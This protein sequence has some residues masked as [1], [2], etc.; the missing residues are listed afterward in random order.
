MIIKMT[1]MI[2]ATLISQPR[3]GRA[4]KPNSQRT[5]SIIP[6]ISKISIAT[7]RVDFNVIF[8]E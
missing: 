6:I 3:P 5:N 4:I 7:S 8:S 2:S 1:A